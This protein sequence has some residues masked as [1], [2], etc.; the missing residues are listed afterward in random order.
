[1]KPSHPPTI[2]TLKKVCS[3]SYHGSSFPSDP[4]GLRHQAEEGAKM[5]YTGE[6]CKTICKIPHRVYMV[7]LILCEKRGFIKK[8]EKKTSLLS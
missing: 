1:M 3:S 2:I 7:V 5:G 4:E 8:M 6:Y